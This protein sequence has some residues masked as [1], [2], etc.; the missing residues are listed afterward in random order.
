MVST[1]ARQDDMITDFRE[2]DGK[3]ILMLSYSSQQEK[4]QKYFESTES[5]P[6]PI[7][8]TTYYMLLGRGFKYQ[9]YRQEVLEEI[10]K[11]YYRIP[12]FLPVGRC[13]M[14][15]WYGMPK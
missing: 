15:E 13:N 11:R 8:E 1:A 6:L 12:D 4:Y 5:I 9:A 10:L 3:N 7:A 2:L 14:Y